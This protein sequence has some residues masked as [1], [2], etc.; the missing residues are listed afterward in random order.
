[1]LLSLGLTFVL[2]TVV[3]SGETAR[4]DQAMAKAVQRHADLALAYEAHVVSTLAGLDSILQRV[5]DQYRRSA[6]TAA[7]S[8]AF[9]EGLTPRQLSVTFSI[10]DDRGHVLFGSRTP[11]VASHAVTAS[12][13]VHQRPG[14]RDVPHVGVAQ[15]G[16]PAGVRQI[17]L[18]RPWYR[19]DGSFGG[20]VIASFDP[21]YFAR[22]YGSI[23]LG[24]GGLVLLAGLD[25]LSR[26]CRVGEVLSYGDDLGDGLGLDPVAGS[27]G[28]LTRS[29]I[30]G[31]ERLVSY[32]V[33]A[34]YPL[35][36]AVGAAR[37]AVLE[38]VTRTRNRSYFIAALVTAAIFLLSAALRAAVLRR[39]R[40]AASLADSEARYRATFEQA[41]I[42]MCHAS[43][44]RRH[45][46]VNRTYCRVLGYDRDELIGMPVSAVIH[47]E[48]RG[49]ESHYR[50][51]L[52]SGEI[53]NHSAEKR[54]VRKDGRV[55]WVNR[56]VSLVR[57]HA[58]EPL[59]F[60]RVVEDVTQRKYLEQELQALA[61][62]DALTGLSNRRSF[63]ARLEE[64]HARIGRFD[65]VRVAVLMLDL[66]WFKRI[67]DTC[68][69][70][71]GDEVL[72][73]VARLIREEPRRVDLCARLGGEEF[74]IILSGAEPEA[75]RDFAERL[76]CKIA[77][78]S[79]AFE[80][81]SVGVT[82][83]I[84]ISAML[85]GDA[86]AD[87]SLSRADAALY[88]AKRNGRN[89]VWLADSAAAGPGAPA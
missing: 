18:S 50:D 8:G 47:P 67:N 74:A 85:P 64:E 71:A 29:W 41:A 59:Y 57:D 32:R 24:R 62:T 65:N 55:I 46:A 4:R 26:A 83:S 37:S 9:D 7:L 69:H 54:Y 48:D 11:A 35:M 77:A 43:L 34:D 27:S 2:W 16:T 52:I 68:G 30:D 13:S 33:L 63:M 6:S 49:D 28:S 70:A 39:D 82:V 17:P 53:E 5:R 73:H 66:D 81:R 40:V 76:R 86:A 1:M 87:V 61:A 22:L 58:G 89:Q 78:A 42:G 79:I 44:D 51:R 23:D 60:L 21:E 45:I 3:L 36:V 31:V 75:A 80:D 38:D 88:R 84:G 15:D 12:L 19:A 20:V 72:R 10:T 25:G 14:A 56:T